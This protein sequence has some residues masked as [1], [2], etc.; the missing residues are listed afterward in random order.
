VVYFVKLGTVMFIKC[1]EFVLSGVVARTLDSQLSVAGS[2][3]VHD[4]AWLFLR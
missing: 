3:L 4:T 1:F 2:N